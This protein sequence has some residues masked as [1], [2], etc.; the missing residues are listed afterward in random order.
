[1]EGGVRIAR[2][3]K[4]G[5]ARIV[6]IGSEPRFPRGLIFDIA[7]SVAPQYH[8]Q[9]FVTGVLKLPAVFTEPPL[10]G[11]GVGSLFLL[12]VVRNTR[13]HRCVLAICYLLLNRVRSFWALR[14]APVPVVPNRSSWCLA[15]SAPLFPPV[16]LVSL[17]P[18]CA[19][20][21]LLCS[22]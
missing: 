17:D 19:L 5:G 4:S 14:P 18:P 7:F 20:R 2:P 6:D 3:R 1:M 12:L 9:I 15:R 13:E 10:I 8:A 16:L 11:Q 21:S 22:S